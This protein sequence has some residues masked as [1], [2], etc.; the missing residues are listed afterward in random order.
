MA[1]YSIKDLEQLSGIKAHTL[2]VWEQ[3]YNIVTPSRTETNIRY[4]SDEHLK[5]LLNVALLNKN[6]VKIS[7]IA[8][9]TEKE[10][11]KQVSALSVVNFE[12]GNQ[13]DALTLSMI[14]MDEYMFNRIV[15]TNIQQLGFEHTMNEVIN[16]FL[17]KL[18]VLW[19]T[20]SVTP[21]HEQFI[22]CLIRR[23]I[24]AEIDKLCGNYKE[25]G[26]TFLIFMP[27]G[28]TQELSLLYLH[29]LLRARKHKVI[30]LG[31]DVSCDDLKTV[32]LVHQPDFLY[33]MVN[34]NVFKETCQCFVNKLTKIFVKSKVIFSGYQM[35][36]QPYKLPK[37]GVILSSF[38]ETVDFLDNL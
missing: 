15:A 23:K 2:R 6:G 3:R 38:K 12:H 20:G 21:L 18:N 26:K 22:S 9:M 5:C 13:L 16:P 31:C 1:I 4:Y 36:K 27:E 24:Q 28:E 11:A 33:T 14:D 29:Y 25:D 7:K 30:Y 17:D 35:L 10:M 19:L 8:K 32:L 34:N 37:N